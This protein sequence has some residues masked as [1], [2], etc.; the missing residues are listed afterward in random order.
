MWRQTDLLIQEMHVSIS[1]IPSEQTHAVGFI[2]LLCRDGSEV[3]W[4]NASFHKLQSGLTYLV[5]TTLFEESKRTGVK[6]RKK[7][8]AELTYD[9]EHKTYIYER[10]RTGRWCPYSL[11]IG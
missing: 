11:G 1:G 8:S 6:R 9:N 7:F 10:P 4:L 5:A 2:W 3:M